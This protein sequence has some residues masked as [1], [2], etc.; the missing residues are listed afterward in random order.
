MG[1]FVFSDIHGNSDAYYEVMRYLKRKIGLSDQVVCIGDL[2]DRGPDSAQVVREYVK[3]MK[4]DPRY[5]FVLGNHE[6]LLLE[7]VLD[8]ESLVKW[9]LWIV[10]G[11]ITICDELYSASANHFKTF[12]DS[13][14]YLLNNGVGRI[15]V[16]TK[17]A[18][19]IT[20]AGM[21][22]TE[23]KIDSG[24]NPGIR[25]KFEPRI[26]SRSRNYPHEEKE[27]FNKIRKRRKNQKLGDKNRKYHVHGHTPTESKEIKRRWNDESY[28]DYATLKEFNLPVDA[29]LAYMSNGEPAYV[30][31][32]YISSDPNLEGCPHRVNLIKTIGR[33]MPY[34]NWYNNL[35]HDL[36]EKKNTPT[37]RMFFNFRN[38]ANAYFKAKDRFDYNFSFL[39]DKQISWAGKKFPKFYDDNY[40]EIRPSTG[41]PEIN[42]T[43]RDRRLVKYIQDRRKKRSVGRGLFVRQAYRREAKLRS[44]IWAYACLYN[45]LV[46]D[47]ITDD[48]IKNNYATIIDGK[49]HT[50]IQN[51]VLIT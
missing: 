8:P 11:G 12:F 26:W 39:M 38:T 36:K 40:K 25:K 45:I 27:R 31:C 13:F 24:L 22:T 46:D 7:A 1:V 14:F 28:D 3:K 49:L 50:A 16:R 21:T 34:H 32:A 33:T 15:Y 44:A 23:S 48:D 18:Y 9:D 19:V 37:T 51:I 5:H 4:S 6:A 2:I 42:K 10:N 41:A 30:A 17:H 29:G 47:D 35:I 20:H 43:P